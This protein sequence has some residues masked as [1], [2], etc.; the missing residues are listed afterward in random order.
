MV[1]PLQAVVKRDLFASYTLGTLM[2]LL[3]LGLLI[4][5]RCLDRKREQSK[6]ADDGGKAAAL[7]ISDAEASAVVASGIADGSH[8]PVHRG[9]VW[10]FLNHRVMKFLGF[11]HLYGLP[12]IFWCHLASIAL[13]SGSYF[14]FLGE[15]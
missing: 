13:Y 4:L 6:A 8:V 3:A 15:G 10:R 7:A 11:N 5:G 9:L 14:T 2:A 1:P 12:T